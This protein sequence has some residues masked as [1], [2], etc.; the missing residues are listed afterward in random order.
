MKKAILIC[1]LAALLVLAGCK[2]PAEETAI[3]ET[4]VEEAPEAAQTIEEPK[5]IVSNLK[6]INGIISGTITNTLDK[7]V[8]LTKDMRIMIRGLVVAPNIV[9]CTKTTLN[10]GESTSCSKI[11]GV[12]QAVESNRIVIRLGLEQVEKEVGC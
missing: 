5:E 10:P 3:G 11:N 2:G 9:Q 8:D 4:T 6:C 12:F 7:T 1:I